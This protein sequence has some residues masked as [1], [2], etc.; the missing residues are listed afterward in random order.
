MFQGGSKSEGGSSG[1]I[2][3]KV[4]PLKRMRWWPLT[5]GA[6]LALVVFIALIW[7][8]GE[9]EWFINDGIK[10]IPS[11][12]TRSIHWVLYITFMTLMFMY[13]VMIIES[14]V[15]VGPIMAVP[16]IIILTILMLMA[17]LVTYYLSVLVVIIA[18]VMLVLYL[19]SAAGSSQ[20]KCPHCGRT[21]TSSVGS[22]G[23]CPHC[24]G[25]VRT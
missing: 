6:I 1:N 22:S 13:I 23:T 14:F 18:I 9:T 3:K 21:F 11:G 17:V 2:L 5:I 4:F 12:Y 20:Y 24:G 10:L 8:G 7:N 25:G 16:R 15:V 19:L